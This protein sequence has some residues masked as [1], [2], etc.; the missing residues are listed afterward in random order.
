MEHKEAV[1]TVIL[2]ARISSCLCA[3]SC[4]VALEGLQ[5]CCQ[6]QLHS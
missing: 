1:F 5:V 6:D 4:V 2:L 3:P